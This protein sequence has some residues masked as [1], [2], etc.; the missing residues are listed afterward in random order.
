[1]HCELRADRAAGTKVA[2]TLR[3]NA[4][5]GHEMAGSRF[6]GNDRLAGG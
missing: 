2:A 5:Q 1:M 6:R 3:R 4:A